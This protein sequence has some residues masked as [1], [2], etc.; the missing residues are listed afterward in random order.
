MGVVNMKV[1]FIGAVRIRGTKK[2][3][4]KNYDFSRVLFAKQIETVDSPSRGV[5]G[6][7]YE[8]DSLNLH[9][10]ALQ[11][12][13]AVKLGQLVDLVLEPDPGNPRN[14]LCTGIA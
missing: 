4:G 6:F 7:G 12:F 14:T 3:T 9:P 8:Q 1:H 5:W 13:S 11:K 2:D 10:E